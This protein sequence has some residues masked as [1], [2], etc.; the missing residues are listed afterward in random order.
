MSLG[1][2]VKVAKS[3]KRTGKAAPQFLEDDPS[4]GYL[5]GRRWPV[6]R[7]GL[8]SLAIAAILVFAIELIVR[9]DFA[10]TISFFL[11]PFKPG[12]T[13]IV[14]FALLLIGFDA[15]L[16]RSHQSLMIVAP[17]TLSLAFVGH[18][19]SHYLGDPLYPTDFLYA[20]QIFALLPLLVRERPMT[21]LAMVVG[22]VA[23]LSL[24]VY[25]WRL[26]RRKVPALSRKGR[27]ARLTLAV[28]LLAFF[29]SIMDYATFS[30]TRDRLQIIPIM[31]DQKE[32]Y[33][34]NGFA[35]A[36]ALNVPMAHVSAPPGYS[37]K[38]I[39]AIARPDVTA[40]VP[41]EKPDIIIVMSESFWDPTKLPGVTITP[42][43]IPN[44]RAL[45]SGSMFSPEF[46]GM[47]A[48]IEFEALTGFSNAFLPAGSIPYQQYVR[49]PTPSLATFLKSQGY[50]ARA[51]HPGTNWFWNR[52]AVYA[53]FGF[54]DFK[55]EETLPPM[56][57]RGPLASDAAM[58]D[59]IISEADASDEPVFFFAVSL[60]NHGPYE[61]NR[62]YNPT[63]RVQAPISQ[64]ARESLLSYAE[65]SADAD[66]GLERLVEWAKKRSRPTVIAFFGDHLPPLGPVY[67]ETGF[68]KDNVAPR[69]EASPEAALEHHET[70]LV[71]W[72]N[73]TG[74]AEQMGAVSP[75]FLPY[76][77]LKTAGIS[78]PY[79]TG[80]LGE[81]SERYRVVDRNL[82]LTPAG[83]ATPDWARQ[84][85][86]DPAIRDF[87]LL[88]YDMMFGKRQA[89]PDFFPETVDKDKV[90]AHTS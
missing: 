77:I 33:A 58:T 46:G 7:Y 16:G 57:K 60:Q 13:T 39:A 74:P 25:G 72:S 87:R 53:D 52:G 3:Y 90:V 84:K 62:Y 6:V 42:D 14:V 10:G 21:A 82:L 65:G 19:K 24:L 4:T 49:T 50:R 86:I 75:A 26:W 15:V 2:E 41:A 80:F 31:W 51:I 35:L 68:L 71:I 43:P 89:A 47:T 12:W 70:P 79:Y 30:W 17:L 28:P 85:E 23:G 63:H 20:R 1:G 81:M 27:L 38:A 9:G 64:W 59:E 88:Q 32:N 54:N 66:R 11:Q 37:D 40:S 29:V 44:V 55:S 34:S 36:F 83:E 18:Q 48:N 5:P 22:I 67:V 76:H 8:I 69:K 45:R 73:R 61:P 56:Q 78:H